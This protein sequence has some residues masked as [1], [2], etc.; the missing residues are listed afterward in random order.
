MSRTARCRTYLEWRF[1]C[2]SV[3]CD[4]HTG[5]LCLNALHE[6]V[7]VQGTLRYLG[8]GLYRWGP[9]PI[10]RKV[11]RRGVTR[12]RCGLLPNYFGHALIYVASGDKLPLINGPDRWARSWSRC[13]CSGSQP[14]GD[15]KSSSRRYMAASTFRHAC[16]YL[17]SR[18]VSAPVGL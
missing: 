2:L 13:T 17:P 8:V 1:V 11:P 10:H 4:G 15:Y 7:C 18:K 5:E 16:G 9:D 12:L 14:T 3:S 6:P